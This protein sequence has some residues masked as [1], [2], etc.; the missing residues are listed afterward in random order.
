MKRSLVFL[1]CLLALP[2]AAQESYLEVGVVVFDPGL[3]APDTPAPETE[4]PQ[5]RRAEA[6]Y[7]AVELRRALEAT[8]RW[9]AVRVMP[10]DSPLVDL[11]LRGKILAAT[12][13]RLLLQVEASDCSGKQWL[14]GN[15]EALA[16]ESAYPA[17]GAIDPFDQ[18]YR[19]IA[20]DLERQLGALASGA[21][22]QLRLICRMR[23]AESLSPEAF[24][25]YLGGGG[26]L[27]F[28][29]QRLPAEGD[30]ML[31]RVERIRQQEYLFIDN[32]DEQYGRLHDELQV[33]YNLWRQNWR[34]Q[35]VYERDY[36]Q[37]AAGRE[38]SDRSGSY[39]AMLS[40]YSTY[41]AFRIREQDL[42]E[43]ASG[44][45]NEVGPTVVESRGRVFRLSGSLE[46]RYADWRRVLREI[47]AL[48]MGEIVEQPPIP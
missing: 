22:Q 25:G 6:I 43:L 16:T 34:E 1:L 21:L 23:Y 13:E 5:I 19:R 30:P 28:T 36:A 27:P 14:Q 39:A 10:G 12:G 32:V 40:D 24:A 47:F 48:E 11:T 45:N 26:D 2:L 42:D 31:Q 17:Q 33:T 38:S 15:Y 46:S 41:R 7:Q 9:G 4:F 8:G 44:F 3:A 29:L 37:R 35:A 18:L 20:A